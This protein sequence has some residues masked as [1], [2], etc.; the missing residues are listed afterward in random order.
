MRPCALLWA[1]A[2]MLLVAAAA[3]AASAEKTKEEVQVHGG[4]VVVRSTNG[5]SK[6]GR[7]RSTTVGS[8]ERTGKNT[9]RVNLHLPTSSIGTSLHFCGRIIQAHVALIL[10]IESDLK[11]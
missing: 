7:S 10:C 11:A 5:Q 6:K 8:Y 2:P 4:D 1:W 9:P 3:A